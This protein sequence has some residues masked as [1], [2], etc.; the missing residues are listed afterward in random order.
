MADGVTVDDATDGVMAQPEP[1]EDGANETAIAAPMPE[2]APAAEDAPTDPAPTDPARAEQPG[3]DA[4]EFDE[5]GQPKARRRGRRGGRRRRRDGSDPA[6]EGAAPSDQAEARAT[7]P[8]DDE[9]PFPQSSQIS[10]HVAAPFYVPQPYDGPTPANPF[11]GSQTYDIFDMIDRAAEESEARGPRVE[12]DIPPVPPA[13]VAPKPVVLKP[14]VPKPVAVAE[15][16]PVAVEPVVVEPVVVEPVVVEPE[17]PPA[18]P[19]RGWWR[20]G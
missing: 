9:A 7:D 2:A 5:N 15:P 16:E 6:A 3:L 20:K 10:Q 14:V 17:T 12:M 8:G 13:A 11:G 1:T 19:K 4:A 18:E